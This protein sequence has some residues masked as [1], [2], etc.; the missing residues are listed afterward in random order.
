[1][2]NVLKINPMKQFI[3][4][5]C[6][7]CKKN[8]VHDVLS[9]DE[10]NGNSILRISCRHCDASPFTIQYP[11]EIIDANLEN[12]LNGNHHL[13]THLDTPPLQEN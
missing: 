1:M 5:P 9:K 4:F 10:K 6:T 11:K 13:T 8:T 2:Y 3:N 12:N 7:T